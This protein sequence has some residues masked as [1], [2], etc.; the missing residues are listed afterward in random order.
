M[1]ATVSEG[2][3]MSSS[4]K[5]LPVLVLSSSLLVY[6][7]RKG[8]P[9]SQMRLRELFPKTHNTN[10]QRQAV[11]IL[12][13]SQGLKASDTLTSLYG[14]VEDVSV[15]SLIVAELFSLG[16]RKNMELLANA[17]KNPKLHQLILSR[18]S[19]MAEP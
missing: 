18:L 10:L 2:R 15:K 5:F 13:T 7:A 6:L 17:E 14:S 4:R 1:R 11:A 19:I 12:A 8:D 9:T 16:D 3:L